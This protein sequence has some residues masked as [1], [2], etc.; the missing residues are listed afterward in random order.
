MNTKKVAQLINRAHRY[1]AWA[2]NAHTKAMQSAG[3]RLGK[4]IQHHERSDKYWAAFEATLIELKSELGIL[5]STDERGGD[6]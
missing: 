3:Q 4:A 2:Y 6:A 1:A 5:H